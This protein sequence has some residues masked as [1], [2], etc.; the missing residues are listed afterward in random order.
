MNLAELCV[1]L[2]AAQMR[3]SSCQRAVVVFRANAL[4]ALAAAWKLQLGEL[5]AEG[6][7]KPA[8]DR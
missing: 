7:H 5:E 6:R 1:A 2:L 8:R 4:V 3:A